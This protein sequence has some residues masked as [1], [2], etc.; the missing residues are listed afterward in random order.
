MTSATPPPAERAPTPWRAARLLDA[1][2]RL[3][4][5]WAGLNWAG[6]AVWWSAYLTAAALDAPWPWQLPAASA[7]GL[8]FSLGAM[9]LFIAGFM[10][11]AGPKW[12]RRP[13]VAARALRLPVGLFTLGWA[14]AVLGFHVGLALAATGLALVA[15]GW[16]GLS[17]RIV[18]LVAGSSQADRRHP[19]LIAVASI[20]MVA[21]LMLS[22]LALATGRSDLLHPV[23]RLALWG[24]VTLVFLAVSHRLLP[25]L[26]AGAWPSLD[27][28]WPG[29]PLWLVVSVSVVQSASAI[30]E[31]WLAP[32]PA[33]RGFEAM[34]LAGVAALC[35]WIAL[36][37]TRA[38][39]LRQP[40]V[41][42]LF[43]AFLWWDVALWLAAAARLPGLGA[44]TAA[45]LDLAAV[46][47]LTMGYL[48]GT[49][50]VMA[51]RVS[52]THS[53]RPVAIDGVARALY[54]VLQLAV[55][56]RLAAALAPASSVQWLLWAA[57]AWMSMA[58]VWATRHGGW[59][60][61]PRKDGRPG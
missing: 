61:S 9:P 1:P 39:A 15:M 38:P 37:W 3:C 8:W 16:A 35:L 51:T 46:H 49:L 31:P 10:F 55:V 5:F 59:Q 40:L 11:T 22:S 19:W 45:A 29:W 26:G 33:W 2:H 28:R 21:C 54:G 41:A 6:A 56:L 42:M 58:V 44:S 13:P 43:V 32:L 18:G 20:I 30:V 24:G 7:H 14:V 27:A 34:H 17:W 60:G 47:A 36:R 25:F 52:S 48:A 53:G 23:L 4:F 57:L 12:L 50:L